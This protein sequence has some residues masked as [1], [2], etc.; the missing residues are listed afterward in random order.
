[1]EAQVGG[2]QMGKAATVAV[3]VRLEQGNAATSSGCAHRGTK[4][5]GSTEK[6]SECYVFLEHRLLWM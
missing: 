4:E 6:T 5:S 3:E 2:K 1:M